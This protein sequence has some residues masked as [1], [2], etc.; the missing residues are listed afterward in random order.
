MANY[1]FEFMSIEDCAARIDNKEYWDEY[2]EEWNRSNHIQKLLV[3]GDFI[4]KGGNLLTVLDKYAERHEEMY[5]RNIQN[6][7]LL[8]IGVLMT[9]EELDE[10]TPLC[11]RIKRL[12]K[13]ELVQLLTE[14]LHRNVF[15]RKVIDRKGNI[16][17]YWTIGQE[18]LL[19]DTILD[20]IERVHWRN[21][22]NETFSYYMFKED[23]HWKN[24]KSIW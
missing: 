5:R 4:L 17:S 18:N 1:P 22:P 15:E 12:D 11:H 8:Y 13:E 10:N 19:D 6:S 23:K 21:N 24:N 9:G 3:L 7:I 14:E 2:S 20:N 16:T